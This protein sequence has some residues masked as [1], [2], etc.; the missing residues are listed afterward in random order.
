MDIP[1]TVVRAALFPESDWTDPPTKLLT[2]R[3]TVAGV[4]VRLPAGLP[5]AMA[6]PERLDETEI[7]GA[8]DAVRDFVRAEERPRAFWFVPEAA[9][10]PGLA[11]RLCGLGMRP[12]DD[13]ALEPRNA[14]MAT[15]QPP[16]PGP[17]GIV[18][19]PAASLEDFLAAQLVQADSFELDDELRRAYER[20]AE[21]IWAAQRD[22]SANRT[23]VAQID[24]EVVAFG[25]TMR[26]GNAVFLS[27]GGTRRDRRGRGAYRALVRARWDYAVECGTPALTVGAGSM[28]QPI[29]E[30]LG[31]TVVGWTDCLLDIVG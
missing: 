21:L 9:S 29:L 11:A 24:G 1:A 13:P 6:M 27:G 10:P 15:L 18:T 7:E 8:V 19:R 20:R 5:L 17:E 22:K 30:G 3:A 25:G 12:S 16:P 14:A 28:S 2:R 26:G 31:F 23:F 4:V